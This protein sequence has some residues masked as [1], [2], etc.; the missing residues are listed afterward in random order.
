MMSDETLQRCV[1]RVVV[2]R[3]AVQAHLERGEVAPALEV[4][5][6]YAPFVARL[7]AHTKAML[8]RA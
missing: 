4:L 1:R 6:E 8:D 3:D 2:M 7:D 5:Q